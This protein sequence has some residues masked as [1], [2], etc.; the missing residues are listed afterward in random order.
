VIELGSVG[1]IKKAMKLAKQAEVGMTLSYFEV[2]ELLGEIEALEETVR[3]LDTRDDDALVTH[4]RIADD[5]VKSVPVPDDLVAAYR[6][7][8][9]DLKFKLK[10]ANAM[11]DTLIVLGEVM[12][13]Q[14]G[15]FGED[16]R[17]AEDVW[18]AVVKRWRNE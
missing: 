15:M 4:A 6:K 3:I 8:N 7:D 2:I 12:L 10:Q 18:R 1:K 9:A 13:L 11:I 16:V 17:M 5:A 14:D